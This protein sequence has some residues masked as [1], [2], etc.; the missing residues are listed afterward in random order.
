[1]SVHEDEDGTGRRLLEAV[2]W[3]CR[4][5]S[6][7]SDVPA[8]GVADHHVLQ[9]VWKQDADE[10][11]TVVGELDAASAAQ[12]WLALHDLACAGLAQTAPDDWPIGDSAVI[13]PQ[14]WAALALSRLRVLRK[15]VEGQT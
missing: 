14:G 7:P 2:S 5:L 4:W 11:E 10:N 13:T 1:M 6:D 15:I 12:V 8:L 9:A 3:L